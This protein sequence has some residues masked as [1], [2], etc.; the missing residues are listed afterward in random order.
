MMN[1]G[2]IGIGQLGRR[3]SQRLLDAGY[4]LTV[5]DL[6]KE[7]AKDLLG[8]GAKWKDIP[9]D[10]AE[11][12]QVVLSA[13]PGPSDV[14][15]MVYSMNGLMAGWKKGDIYIDMST[16]SPATIRR[17]A[18]DA[19]AKG[20]EVLD[21]PVSWGIGGPL[22]G[23]LTIMVGGSAHSLQ[24][25]HEILKAMGNQIFH[26]GDVGC[27][28][29]VKLINN[30]I[31]ATCNAATAEGFVLGVKAGIDVR[32]LHEV[33]K[34]SSG[35]NWFLEHKYPRTVFQGKFDPGF[36]I[37]LS[38]KDVG[39][40]LSLGK[41]YCVPQ[42][43]SAVVEQRLLEAKAAGLGDMDSAAIILRLEQLAGVEVRL[44]E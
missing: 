9:K 33:I 29:I 15:E 19:K 28:N 35:N 13:L 21:A 16:N 43:V 5:H 10:V 36:R 38:L 17:V 22:S 12:C 34:V 1:I 39:L 23:T 2:F 40:A 11:S 8:K 24:R 37:N 3:L 25:V 32:K 44:Q 27:G 42:P 18:E 31:A 6:R 4:E 14:E 41:D 26:V 20:V 7:Q 30:M